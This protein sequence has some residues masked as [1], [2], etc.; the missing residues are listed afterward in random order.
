MRRDDEQRRVR[1][2]A[3]LARALSRSESLPLLLEHAAEVAVQTMR[4]A[5]VSISRLEPDGL[6]VRTIVNVGDLGPDEVNRRFLAAAG[7]DALCVDTGYAP[8]PLTSPHELARAAGAAAFEVVRLESVAESVRS[9]P[10]APSTTS[11]PA[12][13]V[14]VGLRL[15]TVTFSFASLQPFAVALLFASPP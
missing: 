8:L 2:L 5:S 13:V 7:V 6:T 12:F 10:P 14:T 11:G 1:S 4:A 15:P 3:A 9:L